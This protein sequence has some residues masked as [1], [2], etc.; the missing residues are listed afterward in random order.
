VLPAAAKSVSASSRPSNAVD[1]TVEEAEGLSE[2][3]WGNYMSQVGLV[4]VVY[5]CNTS[6]KE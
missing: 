1:L 6:D 3:E 2:E 5:C 4:V